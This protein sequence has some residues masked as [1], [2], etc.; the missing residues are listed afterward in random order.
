MKELSPRLA[1]IE[2]EI[3]QNH[4]DF[5]KLKANVTEELYAR[6]KVQYSLLLK[7][8]LRGHSFVDWLGVCVSASVVSFSAVDGLEL[9]LILWVL[10]ERWNLAGDIL[11]LGASSCVLWLML[12]S[13]H[14]MRQC[15]QPL[16][17]FEEQQLSALE[18]E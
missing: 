16:S 6:T 13:L 8:E 11:P 15:E 18:I 4:K 1:C 2:S 7:R 9:V 10:E 5:N 14:P 17:T 3:I 12:P